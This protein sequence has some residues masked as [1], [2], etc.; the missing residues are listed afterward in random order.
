MEPNYSITVT[1][2]NGNPI[3]RE[4]K[5]AEYYQEAAVRGNLTAQLSLGDMYRYGI[6]VAKDD[7]LALKWYLESAL[8]GNASA[9]IALGYCYRNASIGLA[10]N[11]EEAVKWYTKAADQGTSEG[12]N[13]LGF[14]YDNGWGVDRNYKK[15]VEL[16]QKAADAGSSSAQ[17]NLGT[18]YSQG[19]GVD[20][21]YKKALYWFEQSAIKNNFHAQCNLA[22]MYER[23]RGVEK[24][25]DKAIEWY[26]KASNLG[27][28]IAHAK[29]VELL[30]GKK[31]YY[32][33]SQFILDL[34][35]RGIDT[36]EIW[37]IIF[38]SADKSDF[39]DLF[40][41]SQRQYKILNNDHQRLQKVVQHLQVCP[42]ETYKEA[43][44]DFET[45]AKN[46][47]V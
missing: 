28:E 17:N 45:A 27:R 23:G 20:Q 4:A 1:L 47:I 18:M 34:E 2:E 39:F 9:Q 42:A 29:V 7:K 30:V 16:Y 36:S 26:R 24:S 33:A 38:Q 35:S 25:I 5:D 40:V 15:A 22:A 10:R 46:G 41:Q 21:D 11:N 14:M 31:E 37:R 13:N 19:L 3:C 43:M 12:Q 6:N 44:A 32:D 8:G